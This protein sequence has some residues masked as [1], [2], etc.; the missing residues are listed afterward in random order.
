MWTGYIPRMQQGLSSAW[1]NMGE[2][3]KVSKAEQIKTFALI[4]NSIES[5]CTFPMK[6]KTENNRDTPFLNPKNFEQTNTKNI[7][8]GLFVSVGKNFLELRSQFFFRFTQEFPPTKYFLKFFV[9]TPTHSCSSHLSCNWDSDGLYSL[10]RAPLRKLS[11]L[12]ESFLTKLRKG[13]VSL[14]KQKVF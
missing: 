10:Q 4:A 7:F 5:F 6:Q 12:R 8:D 13:I 9:I 11:A 2:A 1:Q 14:K 3:E